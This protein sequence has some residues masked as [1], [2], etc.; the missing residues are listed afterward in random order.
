MREVG[1][2]TAVE[3]GCE[4]RGGGKMAAQRSGSGGGGL[5]Q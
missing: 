4:V 1:E 3:V 5:D 2:T